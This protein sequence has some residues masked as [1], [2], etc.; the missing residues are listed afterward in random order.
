MFLFYLL[1]HDRTEW[2]DWTIGWIDR[3]ERLNCMPGGPP[4]AAALQNLA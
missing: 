4:Q 2:Q 1:V 3:I